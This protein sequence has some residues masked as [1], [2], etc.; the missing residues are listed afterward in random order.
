MSTSLVST[1]VQFPDSSIQPTGLPVGA[2]VIWQKPL[3]E[4]PDGWKICNGQN[5]TP[6]L[7]NQFVLGAGNTR[8][9]GDVG[10]S[11]TVVLQSPEIPQHTH[12]STLNVNLA[13]SHSHNVSVGNTPSHNHPVNGALTTPSSGRVPFTRGVTGPSSARTI[14]LAARGQHSHSVSFGTAG[15]HTHPISTDD[16]S[17][18]SAG[19]SDP[20]EN[21]P[22]F[23]ALYFIM[24]VGE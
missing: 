11:D 10:G 15:D 2:I 14:N 9:I 8:N 7:R 20:H 3:E 4:L 19:E 1:G 23:R 22:P 13:G 17:I 6:D 12:S 21:R 18:G 5:G 24:K 16:I